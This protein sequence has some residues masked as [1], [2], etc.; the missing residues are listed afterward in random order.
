[1]TI[2]CFYIPQKRKN[3]LL[4]FAILIHQKK[5]YLFSLKNNFAD[6]K[7]ISG[8]QKYLFRLKYHICHLFLSS[9][10]KYKKKYKWPQYFKREI[11]NDKVDFIFPPQDI[12]EF[13]KFLDQI[14]PDKKEI[15]TFASRYIL[16]M[17]GTGIE[18]GLR[19]DNIRNFSASLFEKLINKYNNYLF[20]KVGLNNND[21]YL[22]DKKIKNFY[23]L[24]TSDQ[25]S[26]K[27]ETL[28]TLYSRISIHPESG[29][30]LLPKILHTPTLCVNVGHPL[31]NFPINNNELTI[32]KP[33]KKN[34]K[35]LLIDD[36][37][38]L[39]NIKSIRS[40][41]LEYDNLTPED[42]II[43]FDYLNDH[44]NGNLNQEIIDKSNLI[45]EKCLNFLPIARQNIYFRKWIS[46][47]RF[48]G[49]GILYYK[50]LI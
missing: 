28:L 43:G 30:N 36:H 44:L 45:L 38:D 41:D 23:D 46:N 8:F 25:W 50:N 11:I 42:I 22:N 32:V 19:N 5:H 1:M 33:I 31:L 35:K 49:K 16:S 13:E 40:L 15:I 37:L 7:E 20:V 17:K 24:S 3:Y 6:V 48:L 34:N 26:Q 18:T 27:Y 21:N 29:S 14:N 12:E 9:R 47:N 10:I 39:K 2:F 4:K